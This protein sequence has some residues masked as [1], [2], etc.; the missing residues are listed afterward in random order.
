MMIERLY[1][2]YRSGFFFWY[3]NH[4]F[5]LYGCDVLC[6]DSVTNLGHNSPGRPRAAP[7]PRGFPREPDSES[8][9][10]EARSNETRA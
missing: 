3:K 8:S 4:I 9:K 1:D 6:P 5:V 2:M 7:L 10:R